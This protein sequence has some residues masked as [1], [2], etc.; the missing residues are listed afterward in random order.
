M[1]KIGEII[2]VR[3]R[4][5]RDL[6]YL[7]FHPLEV[8]SGMPLRKNTTLLEVMMTYIQDG[9]YCNRKGTKHC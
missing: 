8:P 9:P 3:K 4:K 7:K 6:H 2:S 5:K 1:S